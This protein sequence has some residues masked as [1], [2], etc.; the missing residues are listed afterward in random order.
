M[1]KIFTRLPLIC[2][3][4]K[5]DI[6]CVLALTGKTSFDMQRRIQHSIIKTLPFCELE[7]IFKSLLRVANKFNF[8]EVLLKRSSLYS[9]IA[10]CYMCHCCNANY[11]GKTKSH[12]FSEQHNI[13]IFRRLQ[14]NE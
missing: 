8:K 3:M 11:H 7:T 14:V 10:W 6:L 5:K 1:N 12:L 4:S 13:W 2:T 9:G